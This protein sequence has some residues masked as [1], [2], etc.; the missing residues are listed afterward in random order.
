MG[1]LVSHSKLPSLTVDVSDDDV[2]RIA[3][4]VIGW[5][6]ETGAFWWQP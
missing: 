4:D 5:M 2:D 6:K 3:D 1:E